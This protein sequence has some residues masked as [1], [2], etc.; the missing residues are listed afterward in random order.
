MIICVEKK[1][2]KNKDLFA[3][4]RADSGHFIDDSQ[5]QRLNLIRPFLHCCVAGSASGL[6][7]QFQHLIHLVDATLNRT[8]QNAR[9]Q[10]TLH[11]GRFD[12]Q[13]GGDEWNRDAGIWTNQF[14]QHLRADIPK[15]I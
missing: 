11:F 15:Q 6:L 12:I 3:S 13:L 4:G 7:V 5:L 9:H 8:I 10:Q 2:L 14:D 1:N